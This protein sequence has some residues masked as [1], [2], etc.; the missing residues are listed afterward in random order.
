M[1]AATT[2]TAALRDRMLKRVAVLALPATP[3]GAYLVSLMMGL[4]FADAA[5]ALLYAV[6]LLAA[7]L[8]IEGAVLHRSV[9]SAFAAEGS[10]RLRRLLELPRRIGAVPH[11][12]AWVSAGVV[13][14]L[15]AQRIFGGTPRPLLAAVGGLFVGLFTGPLLEAMLEEEV[16]PYAVAELHRDPF[17]AR[18]GGGFFRPRQ[19]WYL[20]WAFLVAVASAI[21][22]TILSASL[23][24]ERTRRI[25][26]ENV[27]LFGGAAAREMIRPALEQADREGVPPLLAVGVVFTI[28]VGL[29]GAALARRQARAA[30]AVEASL[31]ALADGT[32]R[33]PAWV[34]TDEIGDLAFSTARISAEMERVY[35]RLR[36]MAAGDL[37]QDL[38]GDSGLVTAFRESQRGLRALSAML[39]ALARGEAADG[40]SVAGDLGA[41]FG[42]L[43]DALDG[44]VHQA[45]TIAQG[46][47]SRDVSAPGALG[48][49]LQRM[50]TNLRAIAVQ[51]QTVS[52]DVGDIVVHLRAAAA[53]LTSATA[54]QVSAITETANTVTE[55][56]QTSAVS[57]ER[58]AQLIARGED[59]A[60]V[61]ERGATTA[62]AASASMAELGGGLDAIARA[63]AALADRVKRIE[64]ITDTVGFISD[65][66]ATLAVNAAVEAA[67][68]GEAG[69]GFAVVAREVRALASDSRK[70]AGDI[71]DLLGEIRG[72]MGEVD[73]AVT[74]GSATAETG[75]AHVRRLAEAIGQLGTAVD[76]AVGLMRQVEGSARQ[77]QAGIGQVT[78][79]LTNLKAASEGIREGAKLLGDLAGKATSASAAL[80]QSAGAYVLPAAQA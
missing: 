23:V 42:R 37:G 59:T 26:L 8:A 55:M 48:A 38:E 78:Q 75:A 13:Y 15:V 80:E 33:L 47:L 31:R 6:P 58:A 7:A 4:A 53:Q 68:A 69:R 17:A 27:E 12:L 72:R 62:D 14:A 30:A 21:F 18:P 39:A 24:A 28:G 46:D 41:S 34:A 32:P 19:R 66:S 52:R 73:R 5:R 20:P 2:E 51:T 50:T 57:A 77:H 16:R 70:A 44:I 65:Q 9:R 54:E 64:G 79:A 43:R 29:T 56:A 11:V 61:A 22:F 3:L 40:G 67:R 45:R 76:E 35:A 71:R 10:L 63:S 1:T 74:A 49:S 60:A 36:A 25:A